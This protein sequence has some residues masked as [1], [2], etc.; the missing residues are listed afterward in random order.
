MF[1][2][3]RALSQAHAAVSRA[4]QNLAEN[5]NADEVRRLINAIK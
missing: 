5:T 4:E 3:E 2:A 1:D